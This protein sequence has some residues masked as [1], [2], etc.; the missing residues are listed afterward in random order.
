MAIIKT[1][2]NKVNRPIDMQC[3][4]MESQCMDALEVPQIKAM[5]EFLHRYPGIFKLA[6]DEILGLAQTLQE[7]NWDLKATA[8]HWADVWEDNA[9]GD[10]KEVVFP[11]HTFG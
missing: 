5:F 3:I 2:W 9:D 10:I 6:P 7:N 1:M 4:E 11:E 8:E